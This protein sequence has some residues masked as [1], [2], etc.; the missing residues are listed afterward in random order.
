MLPATIPSPIMASARKYRLIAL[1]YNATVCP[2]TS[3]G[4]S[5]N[6]SV[7]ISIS[8]SYNVFVFNPDG[9]L[10]KYSTFDVYGST[11]QADA[12]AAYL[13][14]LPIGTMVAVAS[15]DEPQANRL[16]TNL[17]TAMRRCGA[18]TTVYG[19]SAFYYRSAY[20]LI[21]KVSGT[22]GTSNE[23][24]SGVYDADVNAT[25]FTTVNKVDTVDIVKITAMIPI[26]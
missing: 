12:M 3:R 5:Q 11:A 2:G 4:L 6:G 17:Y 19:K 13:N 14:A 24:Y 7:P 8:R 16:T 26:A 25:P 10:K 21:G 15:H 1:G 18:S 22:A 9:S 23:W 20:V